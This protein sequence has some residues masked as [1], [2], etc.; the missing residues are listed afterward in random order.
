MIICK[1]SIS[2]EMMRI[3]NRYSPRSP[4]ACCNNSRSAFVIVH[5]QKDKTAYRLYIVIK[6]IKYQ[7]VSLNIIDRCAP[8]SIKWAQNIKNPSYYVILHIIHPCHKN[9][10]VREMGFYIK[11]INKIFCL[12][13]E[14][15]PEINRQNGKI[16]NPNI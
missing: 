11:I 16:R 7:V 15:L 1:T 8:I 3:C 13:T 5:S 9:Q 4:R 6:L 14:I 2:S 12:E 10:D